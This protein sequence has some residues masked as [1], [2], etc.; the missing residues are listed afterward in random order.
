MHC[1]ALEPE[2][3]PSTVVEQWPCSLFPPA[4]RARVRLKASPDVDK[5][6]PEEMLSQ[7]LPC[8][9]VPGSTAMQSGRGSE[10]K[11]TASDHGEPVSLHHCMVVEAAYCRIDGHKRLY[12]LAWHPEAFP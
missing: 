4:V 7:A 3:H 1:C 11:R 5:E 6:P 9:A 10:L 12:S 2:L 8:S